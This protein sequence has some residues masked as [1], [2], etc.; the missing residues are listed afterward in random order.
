MSSCE[1]HTQ[2]GCLTGYA[3]L[4]GLKEA[5][6]I[7]SAL[8]VMNILLKRPFWFHRAPDPVSESLSPAQIIYVPSQKHFYSHL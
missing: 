3:S 1:W 6:W 7:G 2:A 5:E 8:M 4:P